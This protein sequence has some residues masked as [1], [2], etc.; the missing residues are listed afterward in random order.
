M[1]TDVVVVGGGGCGLTAALAAAEGGAEVLLLEKQGRP[2][3]N[4]ARSGG[5]I[6]AAGTRFQRDA[7]IVDRPED[8]AADILRKNGHSSD[9]ELTLRLARASAEL[10]EWLVDTVGARLALINDFKYP[11]HG[12]FRMHAPPGR[13]G[14]E[15]VADLRRAAEAHPEIILVADAPVVALVADAAGAVTGVVARQGG[16]VERVR[17]GA[18]ILACNG[19]AGNPALVARYCPAMAGALYFGGEGNTGEGIV[20]GLALGADVAY[21]DAF[22]A[23][24][25][26][27]VP[28]NILITYAVISEGGFQVDS[29]GQRFGNEMSG[30]SEHALALLAQPGGVAWNVYDE[31][32]HRLGLEFS[33]YREAV[34]AGAVRR[35]ATLAALAEAIGVDAEGLALTLDEYHAAAG[36]PADRFGRRVTARLAPPFYGVKVTGALFHTQG[37]LRADG[38]G[39]VLRA[40]GAPVPNLYAGG[41]VAAGISGHGA[42]GYL[43]GNGLL[44]ALGLGMLAGRHAARMRL[45]PGLPAAGRD[46]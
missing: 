35:G 19:F 2:W 3:S 28:H 12:Q 44:T 13:T 41:G 20:W 25:S 5:M 37:G 43:S 18:T 33:D 9:P 24:A 46:L 40:D 8:F 29:A 1:A 10:V 32:I 11:G 45:A 38:D 23:H 15:L 4:T 7:G 30:Y 26:V 17:A 36:Q 31:R 42:G 27:A 39:R 34:E 21:M 14:A 22:Q 16:A 6:P